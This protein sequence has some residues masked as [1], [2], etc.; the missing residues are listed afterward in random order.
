MT[1]EKE[2]IPNEEIMPDKI[3]SNEEQND[4]NI[5]NAKEKGVNLVNSPGLDSNGIVS[6]EANVDD[7]TEGGGEDWN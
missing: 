3:I 5:E 7:W 6:K 4:A 1:N 2:I